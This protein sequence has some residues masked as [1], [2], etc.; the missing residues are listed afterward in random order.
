MRV[1]CT[2]IGLVDLF[3]QRPKIIE[4]ADAEKTS[5]QQVDDTRDPFFEVE[6][7][8]SEQAEERQENPSDRVIHGARGETH[9]SPSIHRRNQEQI[10]QP[11]DPEQTKREEP[12]RSTDLFTVIETVG[13]EETEDPNDVP[14]HNGMGF[15]RRRISR[16]GG[17][18]RLGRLMGCRHGT[19]L[20]GNTLH[21]KRIRDG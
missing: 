18:W 3:V 12:N 2:A 4:P 21:R 6:A 5:G 11:P 17:H 1:H 9:L 10:D 15:G 20:Q 8:D 19:S 16:R 7:V 14:D 13:A